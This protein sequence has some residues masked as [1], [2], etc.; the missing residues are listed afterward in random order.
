MDGFFQAKH[1]TGNTNINKSPKGPQ[2]SPAAVQ[3]VKERLAKDAM[4]PNAVQIVT[5]PN[6]LLGEC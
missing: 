5:K 1:G 2:P 6:T 4:T 3:S